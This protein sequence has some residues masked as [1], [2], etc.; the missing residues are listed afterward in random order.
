MYAVKTLLNW[1]RICYIFPEALKSTFMV[2]RV[3]CI[4]MPET[5]EYARGLQ[6]C[7]RHSWLYHINMWG[8]LEK[9]HNF[10]SP[11][12]GETYNDNT[13]TGLNINLIL[14]LLEVIFIT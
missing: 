5:N 6:N 13:S 2:I 7:A 10:P 1:L 11:N 3:E 4:R 14:F 8:R 9:Q 12:V